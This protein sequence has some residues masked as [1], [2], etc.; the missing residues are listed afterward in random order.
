MIPKIIH[1]VWVGDFKIPY[2]E[3][4]LMDNLRSLHTDYEYRLW[5]DCEDMPDNVRYWYNRFYK[6]KNYVFCADLLR[7]WVVYKY[8]GIY[9]DV[10]FDIKNRLDYFTNFDGMFCYHNDT[11]LTIPNNIFG[12]TKQADILHFCLNGVM[13]SCNWY[14]PSWFGHI[15]KKYLQLPYEAAQESVG[16]SLRKRNIAYYQYAEFERLY[17]KHLSL[18]SWEPKTW[19]RLNQG[20]QL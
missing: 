18:Y 13:Q 19:N 5:T 12:A 17:G 14:G 9:L 3:K 7:I 2:R 8:G 20:E 1:Q 6:I 11:D 10:D 16:G 4:L 15:I